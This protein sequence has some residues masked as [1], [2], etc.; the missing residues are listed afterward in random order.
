VQTRPEAIVI[1][2]APVFHQVRGLL[3]RE[4]RSGFLASRQRLLG[5]CSLTELEIGP[6][7]FAKGLSTDEPLR[8]QGYHSPFLLFVADEAAGIE[9]SIFEAGTFYE[10]H[11]S[12]CWRRFHISAFGVPEPLMDPGWIEEMA[13]LGEDSPGYQV[14]VLGELPEQGRDA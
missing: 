14:R 13:E 2:T 7:W 12:P 9:E 6:R 8:F 10:T 5:H 11:R 3:W 1:T 4:I